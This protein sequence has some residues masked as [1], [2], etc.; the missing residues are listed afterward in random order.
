MRLQSTE[1]ARVARKVKDLPRPIVQRIEIRRGI[2]EA[3]V[4]PR[5]GAVLIK[6]DSG[7]GCALTYE[8]AKALKELLNA[9]LPEDD[10]TTAVSGEL[11]PDLDI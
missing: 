6:M 11:V 7:T 4:Y 3:V 9:Q 5:T 10:P 2:M 8:E 1:E